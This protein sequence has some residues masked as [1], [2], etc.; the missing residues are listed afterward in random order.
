[1][2][3]RCLDLRGEFNRPLYSR[4]VMFYIGNDKR[5][6]LS[7]NFRI[8]GSICVHDLLLESMRFNESSNEQLSQ[9]MR[10]RCK[11]RVRLP[12]LKRVDGSVV[13]GPCEEEQ[14]VK[15]SA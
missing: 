2:I 13:C 1:M 8:G 6:D 7:A 12:K 3:V 9:E 11:F 15:L 10:W 5:K 4:D 14:D